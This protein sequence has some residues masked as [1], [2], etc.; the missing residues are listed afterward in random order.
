MAEKFSINRFEQEIF[1]RLDHAPSFADIE[2][3]LSSQL[4]IENP[5]A[6]L[7]KVSA[8]A[9]ARAG[10]IYREKI[11]RLRNSLKVNVKKDAEQLDREYAELLKLIK[12]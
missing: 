12:Y 8:A 3:I 1:D 4:S 9:R 2:N 6:D 7:S 5:P 10:Q 11:F